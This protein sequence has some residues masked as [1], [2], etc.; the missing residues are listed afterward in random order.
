MVQ[1]TT[2][3]KT[4]SVRFGSGKFEVGSDVESLTNLGA[5]NGIKMTEEWEEVMLETDNAGTQFMGIVNQKIT[6]EGDMLESDLTNLYMIRGG[7]DTFSS[8]AGDATSVTDE[9]H[10]L[11]SGEIERLTYKNGAGTKVTSISVTS[12]PA[13]TSYSEGTD[14]EI[15]VDDE[16]YSCLVLIDG[17]GITSGDS[18][19]VDYTYT[20]YASVS[21]KSGGKKTVSSKVVRVTNTN[22]SGKI[23]RITA[24]KAYNSQGI[25]LELNSDQS[26]DPNSVH[27]VLKG[28]ID[29]SRS[30]GDQ[31]FEIY[32]EQSTT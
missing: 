6:L 16:G 19:L 11:T 18:L 5:M 28:V 15:V 14:Y 24:Y 23:F 1:Q 29:S 3:Q 8:V 10:V 2:I 27:V 13:G 17:G 21:L 4:N 32:D 31:L 9:V 20:P 30:E 7:I 26:T 12:N 25:E 22:A